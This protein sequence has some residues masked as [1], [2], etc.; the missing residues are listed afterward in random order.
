MGEDQ[1]YEGSAAGSSCFRSGQPQSVLPYSP[2]TATQSSASNPLPLVSKGL[3]G[4]KSKFSCKVVHASMNKT[5]RGAPQFEVLKQT[6]ITLSEQCANMPSVTTLARERF[7][8]DVVLVAGNGLPI[9]D[10]N[11]TRGES[12]KLHCIKKI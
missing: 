2:A 11:G 7:G 9:E 10:E 4:K 1:Q 12:E 5:D 8:D 3:W 6:Y